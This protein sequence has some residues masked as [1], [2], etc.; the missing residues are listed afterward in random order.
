MLRCQSC[1]QLMVKGDQG[2]RYRAD[3]HNVCISCARVSSGLTLRPEWVVRLWTSQFLKW[4]Q[5]VLRC[6]SRHAADSAWHVCV[7]TPYTNVD[8]KLRR[9]G[10]QVVP[11]RH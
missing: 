6:P 7:R 4:R 11:V 1:A 10:R 9:V 2:W 3:I 8:T 5:V